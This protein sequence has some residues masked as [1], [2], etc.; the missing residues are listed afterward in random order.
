MGCS[1]PVV[2]APLLVEPSKPRLIYD[3]RYANCFLTI[4]GN[5]RT[6]SDS[7][8]LLESICF[9][10]LDHKSGYHH[11]PLHPDSWKYFGVSWEGTFIVTQPW[12]LAGRLL[13][14]F[15]VLSL[16]HA[17]GVW[18]DLQ[19]PLSL[20]GSM[21]FALEHVRFF[22]TVHLKCSSNRRIELCSSCPWFFF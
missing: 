21:I 6:R 9:V 2:I 7:M 16:V 10:T 8:L 3:A 18:G 22:K 15:V 1:S 4:S 19:F 12:L 5:G 20:I 11:V 13:R 17:L 14:A